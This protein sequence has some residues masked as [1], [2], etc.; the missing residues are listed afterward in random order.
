MAGPQ[1]LILA[2]GLYGWGDDALE[3][4]FLMQYCADKGIKG[5]VVAQAVRAADSLET[6]GVAGQCLTKVQAQFTYEASIF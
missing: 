4:P 3:G 5:T 2:H 1:L 6:C